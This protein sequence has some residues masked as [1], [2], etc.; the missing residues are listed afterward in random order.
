MSNGNTPKL[1]H[2]EKAHTALKKAI[3]QGL[4][5]EGAFLS[6]ADIMKRYGVGRTPYREACNRLHHEGLLEVVPRRGYLIPEVSFHSV[7]DLFEMRLVLEGAIAELAAVRATGQEI[8]EIEGLANKPLPS[9]TAEDEFPELIEANTAFHLCLAKMT[10]NR[11]LVDALS[12]N[13]ERTG[14]L[15]YIELRSSRFRAKEFRLL[16]SRIVDALGTRD[17]KA[18]REA[19]LNDI[20]EAQS[21]TLTLGG[22]VPELP[23]LNSSIR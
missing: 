4:L 18:V 9:S 11:E 23:S 5:Q 17:P 13:L 14:R 10:R 20:M 15:M 16:H 8:Q 21:A 7:C 6:E 12:R 3:L 1:T 19:V 2:T 22:Q